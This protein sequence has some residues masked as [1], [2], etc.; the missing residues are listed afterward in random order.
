M[1]NIHCSMRKSYRGR[2]IES[3]PKNKKKFLKKHLTNTIKY[4]I[5]YIE[6]KKR[7]NL[8]WKNIVLT[9]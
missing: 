7:G 3:L 9:T 4:D 8:K 5:I 1:Q 6:I 2:L